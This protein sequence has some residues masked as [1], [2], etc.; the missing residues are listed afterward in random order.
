MSSAARGE[1][2]SPGNIQE[3]RQFCQLVWEI[4]RWTGDRDFLERRMPPYAKRAVAWLWEQADD[5]DLPC[6][7]GIIERDVAVLEQ[8]WKVVESTDKTVSL[9]LSGV[10]KYRMSFWDATLWATAKQHELTT[11]LSE[12]GPS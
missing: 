4:V 2:S 3:T 9:A 5:G 7:Y 8:A 1:V 10:E 12:D 11:I 6:G